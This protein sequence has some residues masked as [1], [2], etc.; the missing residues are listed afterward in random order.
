[1]QTTEKKKTWKQLGLENWLQNTCNKIGY[2]EPTE[3]Q[4]QAIPEISKGK[5]VLSISIFP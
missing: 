4:Q 3:I 5:D 1:M 2:K